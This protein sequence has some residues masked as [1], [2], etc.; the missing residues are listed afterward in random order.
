MI[1]EASLTMLEMAFA[2]HPGEKALHHLKPHLTETGTKILLTLHRL[3][4]TFSLEE[5]GDPS[6]LHPLPRPRILPEPSDHSS[7]H[8]H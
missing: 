6:T 1:Y 4:R 2:H 7:H 8:P 5:P 3:Y